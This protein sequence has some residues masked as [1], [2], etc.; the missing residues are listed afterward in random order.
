MNTDVAAETDAPPDNGGTF[1]IYWI[2]AEGGAAT[3][4][5][6]PTGESLLADSG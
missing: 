2:D 1:R 6:S 3:L 5:I 4:L